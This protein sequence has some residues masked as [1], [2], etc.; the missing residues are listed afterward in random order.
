MKRFGL[1]SRRRHGLS[2]K[3][4]RFS[5]FDQD[6]LADVPL[7]TDDYSDLFGVVKDKPLF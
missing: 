6:D 5:T 4:L 7:W 2:E 3:Q 1:A